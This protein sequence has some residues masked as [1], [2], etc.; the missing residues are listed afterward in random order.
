MEMD[1]PLFEYPVIYEDP[2]TY[3]NFLNRLHSTH[4]FNNTDEEYIEAIKIQKMANKI[5]FFHTFGDS[6]P[7]SIHRKNHETDLKY[8]IELI[9]ANL[10][11]K[12][13]LQKANGI[14]GGAGEMGFCLFVNAC[15]FAGELLIY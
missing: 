14:S 15:R 6:E 1:W 11:H 9:R 12:N 8:E 7:N 5:S 13:N 3:N 4:L 2:T 10:N